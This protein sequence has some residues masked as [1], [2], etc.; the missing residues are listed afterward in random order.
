MDSIPILLN[1]GSRFAV[2]GQVV[3]EASSPKKNDAKEA[4]AALALR[5]LG[6]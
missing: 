1:V 6:I 2:N 4:A 3:A 5:R